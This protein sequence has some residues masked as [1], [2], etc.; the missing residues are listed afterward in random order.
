MAR[1]IILI[2]AV[3]SSDIGFRYALWADVPAARQIRYANATATT[4]VQDASQSEIAAIQAGAI[5]EKVDE[6]RWPV[7]T[8]IVQVQAFLI[9]A[10][11]QF[12]DAVTARNPW[13]RSGTSWDGAT[14]DV[15]NNG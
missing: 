13:Q 15:K 1:K 5:A 9:A 11:N 7:G 6:A 8:T 3:E 14:W 4:E 10:F 12:Q 2:R